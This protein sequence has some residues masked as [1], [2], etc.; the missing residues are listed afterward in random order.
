MGT[1]RTRGEYVCSERGTISII[2]FNLNMRKY[3]KAA[4]AWSVFEINEKRSLT[5]KRSL[6]SPFP[7]L[8][9]RE[10]SFPKDI[11]YCPQGLNDSDSLSHCW[12]RQIFFFCPAN[13][14]FPRLL[15]QKI[16]QV[17]NCIDGAGGR[18]VGP[19]E[20]VRLDQFRAVFIDFRG[21]GGGYPYGFLC[22]CV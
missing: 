4:I 13:T 11:Q 18:G 9:R 21:E 19:A 7:F 5:L 17:V 8:S 16:S 14:H 12:H 2:N 6:G 10:G 15:L 20:L 22:H 3:K 1:P